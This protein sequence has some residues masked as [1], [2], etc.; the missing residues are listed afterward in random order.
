MVSDRSA[1]KTKWCDEGLGQP[2]AAELPT[3][4]PPKGVIMKSPWGETRCRILSARRWPPPPWGVVVSLH[5]EGIRE[6]DRDDHVSNASMELIQAPLGKAPDQQLAVVGS[7]AHDR[8]ERKEERAL[9]VAAAGVF[10][11][12]RH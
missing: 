11:G 8:Q 12:H 5:S 6:A 9:A 4:P 10:H 1:I 2:I 3:A 7:A